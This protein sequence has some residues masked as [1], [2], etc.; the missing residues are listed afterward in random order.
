MATGH[1][2]QPGE[3]GNPKGRPKKGRAISDIL[4]E[5]AQERDAENIT[6]LRRL[7]LKLWTMAEDGDIAAAK[8]ILPYIEPEPKDKPELG[9]VVS[10]PI[11][12][13]DF[14]DSTNAAD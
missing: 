3:S 5:I 14:F 12:L 4:A 9:E 6:R 1:R 10:V 8:V 7:M 2:W 13:L 11:K